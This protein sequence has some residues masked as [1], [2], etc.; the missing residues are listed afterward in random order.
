MAD[1]FQNDPA[2][3]GAASLW[4]R[5]GGEEQPYASEESFPLDARMA[6]VDD[7]LS[8]GADTVW[9]YYS[10]QGRYVS[11]A[12]VACPRAGATCPHGG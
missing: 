9:G 4:M 7:D 3:I 10:K 12:L 2:G 6:Y 5:K 8:R 11:R 1:T